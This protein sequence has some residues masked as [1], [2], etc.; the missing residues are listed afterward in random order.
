M[1]FTIRKYLLTFQ[2]YSSLLNM[3]ISQVMM[4]YSAK[5][6]SNVIRTFQCIYCLC[7]LSIMG[8]CSCLFSLWRTTNCMG[9]VKVLFSQMRPSSEDTL[10]RARVR[11]GS[12][13]RFLQQ[14]LELACLLSIPCLVKLLMLPWKGFKGKFPFRVILP[15]KDYTKLTGKEEPKN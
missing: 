8:K 4:S 10:V 12:Y 7:A 3:Q 14:K 9:H 13:F 1:L 6:W 5:F 15:F 11:L 2:R